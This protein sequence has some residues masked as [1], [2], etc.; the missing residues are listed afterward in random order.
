M[1]HHIVATSSDST[2]HSRSLLQPVSS[3]L[4]PPPP[5]V[6]RHRQE[7][8]PVLTPVASHLELQDLGCRDTLLKALWGMLPTTKTGLGVHREVSCSVQSWRPRQHPAGGGGEGMEHSLICWFCT[9][10]QSTGAK[11]S[12]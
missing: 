3:N 1:E 11:Y 2:R 8:S 5:A 12:S 10:N 6:K 9:G 4:R 7:P